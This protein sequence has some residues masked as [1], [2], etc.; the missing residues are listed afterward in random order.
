MATFYSRDYVGKGTQDSDRI[1]A[2]TQNRESS[3]EEGTLAVVICALCD[4]PY[5]VTE[6]IHDVLVDG[7][8]CI[9]R[10]WNNQVCV[11]YF[12]YLFSFRPPPLLPHLVSGTSHARIIIIIIIIM[13]IAAGSATIGRLRSTLP[14]VCWR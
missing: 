10:D 12:E 3:K 6:E 8:H 9:C 5:K 7:S 2:L 1:V 13:I 4:A 11:W 14:A